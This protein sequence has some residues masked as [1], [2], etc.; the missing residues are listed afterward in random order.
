MATDM[1]TSPV[2]SKATWV[3]A[4]GLGLTIG[5]I[6]LF[7]GYPEGVM[8]GILF[9]NTFVPLLNHYLRPRILG[10]RSKK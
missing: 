5:I 6:R 7:S 9:M 2:T 3:Y 8:Y 1:V 4:L 10:Q